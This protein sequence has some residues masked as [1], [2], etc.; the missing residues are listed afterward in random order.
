VTVVVHFQIV[1]HLF[2][3]FAITQHGH[4]WRMVKVEKFH[5]QDFTV[6]RYAAQAVQIRLPCGTGLLL[7]EPQNE[8]SRSHRKCFSGH[9]EVS[10]STAQAVRYRKELKGALATHGHRNSPVHNPQFPSFH[11]AD[12][13]SLF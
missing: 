9:L 6:D 1:G 11:E 13:Q 3:A 10:R 4:V 5:A 8:T 7:I 2:T 12:T